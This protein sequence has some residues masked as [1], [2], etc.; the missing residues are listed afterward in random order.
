VLFCR[1]E[2]IYEVF[3][4]PSFQRSGSKNRRIQQKKDT[5]YTIMAG[6]PLCLVMK[7]R[8]QKKWRKKAN[9]CYS[10]YMGEIYV[11]HWICINVTGTSIYNNCILWERGNTVCR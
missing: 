5:K 7:E 11:S 8:K 6:I 4:R 9:P 2:K 3:A 10:I 1:K